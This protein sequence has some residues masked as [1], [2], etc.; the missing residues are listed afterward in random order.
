[1]GNLK[2]KSQKVAYPYFATS[3]L[4]FFLQIVFGL[5]SVAKYIWPDFASHWMA[6]NVSR[7]IH[8]N[9]LIFWMFIAI[10][11]AS[12][13]IVIEQ[14]EKELYSIKLAMIQLI[15]LIIAGVGAVISFFFGYYDGQGLEYVEAA[16]IFDWIIVGAALLWG[17]NIYMTIRKSPK[18]TIINSLMFITIISTIFM[19]LPG[20]PFVKNFVVQDYLRWWVV[21][22]Y[23][24]AT[25]EMFDTL[26]IGYLIIKL[27]DIPPERMYKWFYVEFFLILA[28]GILGMGHHYFWIGTP[29]YWTWV[30]SLFSVF[31][32]VPPVAMMIDGLIYARKSKIKV[33]NLPVLY[34]LIGGSIGSFIGLSVLGGSQTWFTV[35]YWMHGTEITSA[36]GHMAFFG[37]FAATL[38]GFIYYSID[39]RKG[40]TN[41]VETI[42]KKRRWAWAFWLMN[43]GMILMVLAMEVI[44]VMQISISRVMAQGYIAAQVHVIAW[45]SVWFASG[46]IF[47]AGVLFYVYDFIKGMEKEKT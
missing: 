12:Y 15:L 35:N 11:G 20:M 41:F 33:K 26:F 13:Y 17:Y 23:V 32:A 1:M 43:I 27:F 14:A 21:H 37:A 3:V 9:L 31:E 10:M 38:I 46:F 39:V 5:T 16:P 4:L 7:S 29:H 18:K 28:S 24:E 34:W 25:W 44:G 2:F 42:V 30:G 40:E 22:Y 36:H 45:F 8:I 47:F 19:Y 6:F